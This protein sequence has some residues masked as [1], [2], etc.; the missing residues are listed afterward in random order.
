MDPRTKVRPINKT[1]NPMQSPKSP[2]SKKMN[3][4]DST[5]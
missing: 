2:V 1:R 5:S 3:K 4:G